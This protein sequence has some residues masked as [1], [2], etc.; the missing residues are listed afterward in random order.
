MTA[1][2]KVWVDQTR[3]IGSGQCVDTAP[4]VFALDES[5]K[6]IVIDPD[7]EGEEVIWEAAEGCPVS[8]IILEDSDTGEQL[9]P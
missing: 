8:A 2:I 7:G 1:R 9:Y 3:C 5:G 4:G 6:A